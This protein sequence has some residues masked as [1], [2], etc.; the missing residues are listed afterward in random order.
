MNE[1]LAADG[2]GVTET[3]GIEWAIAGNY[4]VR[5]KVRHGHPDKCL[6]TADG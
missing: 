6:R 3:D 4:E 2:I 5:V 1:V